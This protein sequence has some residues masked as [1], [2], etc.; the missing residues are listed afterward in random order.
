M[1]EVLRL[2]PV[3]RI[4]AELEP[5]PSVQRSVNRFLDQPM[6]LSAI[7]MFTTAQ[8][9][10]DQRLF[11][12]NYYAK[13]LSEIDAELRARNL[14][15]RVF[16]LEAPLKI[17]ESRD[18]GGRLFFNVGKDDRAVLRHI[19]Y[20][21]GSMEGIEEPGEEDLLYVE[22]ARHALAGD[23][24]RRREQILKARS[25]IGAE[26]RHPTASH[27]MTARGLHVVTKD[28]LYPVRNSSVLPAEE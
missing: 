16:K 14:A 26:L 5:W 22:F 11:H 10:V 3:T 20:Q 2:H 24:T 19:K 7:R 17:Q 4:R 25:L 28:M 12:E 21:L 23:V 18:G 6:D 27:R 13:R 8:T 15:S 9:V 1:S